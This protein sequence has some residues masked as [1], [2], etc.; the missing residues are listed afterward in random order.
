MP[1]VRPSTLERLRDAPAAMV[2]SPRRG[3]RFEPLLARYSLEVL[4]SID[5]QLARGEHALQPLL[6]LHAEPFVVADDELHDWDEASD[7]RDE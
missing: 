4:S 5:A 6:R 3:T 1:H 2:V 7:I